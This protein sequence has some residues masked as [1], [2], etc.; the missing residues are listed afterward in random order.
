[1][2]L[3][4]THPDEHLLKT[5]VIHILKWEEMVNDNSKPYRIKKESYLWEVELE[6]WNGFCQLFNN[7][8]DLY[9]K[10]RSKPLLRDYVWRGHRLNKWK[11]ESSFD[12]EFNERE[13][14][15]ELN[16]K[17]R[18]KKREDISNRHLNSFAYA[19]RGKLKDFDLSIRELKSLLGKSDEAY[20]KCLKENSS[21]LNNGNSYNIVKVLGDWINKGI[22]NRNH[23][24][25]LGQHYGLATPLLDWCYS[26]F[27][28]A[29]FAFEKENNKEK[30][31]KHRVVFGLKVKEV[32]KAFEEPVNGYQLKYFDPMSSEHLRLINQR[33][34]FT[35][36]TNGKDIEAL[37]DD[38]YE[39]GLMNENNWEHDNPWLIKIKIKDIPDTR[40]SF[41]HVLTAMN[42]N[43]MSL[44]P[45][46]QGA[47]KFCNLGIKLEDYARFRGQGPS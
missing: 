21:K 22:L 38:T 23:I 40:C 14:L 3:L 32:A 39:A 16:D 31:N 5:T 9:E 20:E 4:T 41:L 45:E 15:K 26:P 19:C 36:E 34:L 25:A 35:I 29:F 47:A 7:E 8:F 46:I 17:E 10:T 2:Y 44:F 43:H 24:W 18:I 42:I 33:G 27:I 30:D 12:R 11:L 28:A 1:M 37:L 6:T 13:D